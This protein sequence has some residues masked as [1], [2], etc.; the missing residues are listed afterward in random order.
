MNRKN[1][2]KLAKLTTWAMVST[3]SA[4]IIWFLGF[5]ISST[6]DLNVFTEKTSDF[7][8]AF[9][10][11]SVVIVLCSAILNV[12]LNIGLIADSKIQEDKVLYSTVIDKKV[13]SS[14]LIGIL[15]LAAFLFLGDYLTRKNEKDKLLIAA[16]YIVKTYSVS[17]NKIFIGLADSSHVAEIPKTLTF[18][19]NQKSEFPTVT[20]ITSGTY[21]GQMTFLE[22]SKWENSESLKEPFFGNS[23]YKCQDYDC[24]YLSVFFSGKMDESLFWTEKN[25]YKLYFPFEEN[26]VR[27]ILLF[28]KHQRHGKLGS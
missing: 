14:V 20:L 6:F 28:T 24:D 8:S 19:S 18:L 5:L 12:S 2:I 13:Y 22:I 26:D 16:E 21:D 9:V 23:F 17:I 7:M 15:F 27:F 3:I 11:I 4:I 1:K 10:G 25:D